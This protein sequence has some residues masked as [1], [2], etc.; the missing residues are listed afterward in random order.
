MRAGGFLCVAERVQRRMVLAVNELRVLIS[1][2]TG[3]RH[4][5]RQA[6]FVTIAKWGTMAGAQTVRCEIC[7]SSFTAIMLSRAADIGSEN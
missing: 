4:V 1:L 2:T 5:S 6:F 7:R 3:N